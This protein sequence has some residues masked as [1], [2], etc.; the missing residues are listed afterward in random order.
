MGGGSR[1]VGEGGI[2]I[3]EGGQDKQISKMNKR[4]VTIHVE[5]GV[6]DPRMPLSSKSQRNWCQFGLKQTHSLVLVAHWSESCLHCVSHSKCHLHCE[7]QHLPKMGQRGM[8]WRRRRRCQGMPGGMQ[9][10]RVP[11]KT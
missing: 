3:P 10:R 5:M 9:N 1:G 7:C 6:L 8:H 4:W 2:N 11:E